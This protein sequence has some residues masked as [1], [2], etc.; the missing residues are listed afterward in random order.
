M[1]GE[2]SRGLCK[3]ILID[4][5]DHADLL[6]WSNE[7]TAGDDGPLRIAHSQQAFEVVGVSC[8]GTDDRLEGKKQAALTQ[9]GSHCRAYPQ[10]AAIRV[11]FGFCRALAHLSVAPA[12][13]VP[14]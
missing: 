7:C 2:L 4:E 3:N 12:S 14:S 5:P 9:R 10:T 8:Y 13:C 1:A 6:E 11:L